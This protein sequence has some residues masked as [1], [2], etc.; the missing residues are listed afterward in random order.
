MTDWLLMQ[1]A[2]L[3]PC[4]AVPFGWVWRL[5]VL[6]FKSGGYMVDRRA[7]EATRRLRHT[8]ATD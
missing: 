1:A 6:G 4:A 5:L 8:P 7:D 3:I 2:S